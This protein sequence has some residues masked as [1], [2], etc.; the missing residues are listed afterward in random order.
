MAF[1][2]KQK[3]E[4]IEPYTLSVVLYVDEEDRLK[5]A[6]Q[7]L[8]EQKNLHG[9][10]HY[11][12]THSVQILVMDPHCSEHTVQVCQEMQAVYSDIQRIAVEELPEYAAYA[13]AVNEVTGKYVTFTPVSAQYTMTA[14]AAAEDAA[15]NSGASLVALRARYYKEDGKLKN[16]AVVPKHGGSRLV[17]LCEEPLALHLHFNAYFMETEMV[18]AFGFEEALGVDGPNKLLLQML[19]KTE[20][21]YFLKE[22]RYIY[23]IPREDNTSTFIQQHDAEW[24]TEAVQRFLMPFVAEETAPAFLQAACLYYLFA[25]YN[26]NLNERTKSALNAEQL[27]EFLNVSGQLLSCVEETFLVETAKTLCKITRTL[28]FFWLKLRAKAMGKTLTITSDE[29]NIY[30]ST[31]AEGEEPSAETAHPF[32]QGETEKLII[33]TMNYE[34]GV[35]TVDG[36]LSAA[37]FCANE[38]VRL[39]VLC[40]EREMQVEP[41]RT[42][43]LISC[44]GKVIS[45]RTIYHITLPVGEF[46]KAEFSVWMEMGGYRYPLKFEFQ[47]AHSRLSNL[48]GSYWHFCKGNALTYRKN[49]LCSTPVNAL[50]L[51]LKE[52]KFL[53]RG[54][55]AGCKKRK[56]LYILKSMALRVLYWITK[57]FFKRKRIWVTFDKL[58][59][60]GDNG[61]YIYRYLAKQNEGITP[62]YI[63]K[64]D[65]LDYPRMKKDGVRLLKFYTLRSLLVCLNAEVVLDTHANVISYCGYHKKVYPYFRDLFAPEVICIQHGLTTQ[66]IAQFQN[67]LF[68][69]LKLYCCASPNEIQNLLHPAYGY[70]PEQL[71]LTG[72]ARYDGLVN[73]DQKNILITPTWRR[74]VVN[75]NVA[76]IQKKHSEFF[77][78]SEYFRLYDRLIHDEE[79]IAC[80]K[81]CGYRITYLLHPG[82]SA[83]IDDFDNSGYVDVI[84]AYS[85]VNYEKI[86]TE[87]SLMVTD[88]SGV[89]FDFA[90]MRKPLV[91]YHPKTLP[92]HYQESDAFRCAVDGFGSIVDN[93]E[94]LIRELCEYMRGGC[95]MKEEYVARSN[96]FFAFADH[97]NCSRIYE[98]VK[99]YM[100]EK[101]Q[102]EQSYLEKRR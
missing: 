60:A 61:E 70:R 19:L 86:L 13:K 42:Y 75:S 8:L 28:L 10:S 97:D 80:A 31:L 84:A 81:E 18:R 65:S 11:C 98:T 20:K 88:F 34:A 35:I 64:A 91:Y 78:N 99:A 55:V 14:L 27:Q 50:S 25:R 67:R 43:A 17:D 89:Q 90:Y 48:P 69:N 94:E 46:D 40:G 59:K 33:S 47:T 73:N 38:D 6:L 37:D 53:L 16:Y 72:L 9:K 26:C 96:K 74:N 93:H 85:D 62:Y 1:P 44:F 100:D 21:Y 66:S 79:L 3:N 5:T 63:I 52:S 24:Y 4:K 30:F 95:K 45:D 92:P 82:M 15:K 23:R 39:C 36:K 77:R 102:K 2:A 58:F 87:A 68:D 101:R 7:E 51:F 71:K 41:T 56:N 22:E 83:Q 32:S 57:P 29:Q 49:C 12:K 76:H 54:C